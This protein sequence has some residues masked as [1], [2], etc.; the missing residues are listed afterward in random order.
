MLHQYRR[1]AHVFKILIWNFF[2]DR[3]TSFAYDCAETNAER[4]DARFLAHLT[5]FPFAQRP[6]SVIAPA[7][8][9]E[10]STKKKKRTTRR[11][12]RKKSSTTD[13]EKGGSLSCFPSNETF[14]MALTAIVT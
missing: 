9:A 7:G 6:S 10:T 4:R 5:Y 14:V 3:H 12:E 2:L 11:D 1:E 13:G 8:S